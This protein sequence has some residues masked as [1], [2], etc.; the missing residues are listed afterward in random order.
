MLYCL[1][2]SIDTDICIVSD[3]LCIFYFTLIDPEFHRLSNRTKQL[4]SDVASIRK[5]LDYL[6]RYDAVTFYTHLLSL[7]S[8]DGGVSCTLI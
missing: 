4:V 8:S 2:L 6:I 5:L 3:Y 7:L 1:M